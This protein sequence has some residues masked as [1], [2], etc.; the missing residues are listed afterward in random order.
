M[1]E[2]L[3][4][5]KRIMALPKGAGLDRPRGILSPRK[6]PEMQGGCWCVEIP[7][8]KRAFPDTEAALKS[9]VADVLHG[10]NALHAAGC[11]HRNVQASNILQVIFMSVLIILMG[12]I[13]MI[14]VNIDQPQCRIARRCY[15]CFSLP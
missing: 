11:V 12:C 13:A 2:E 6:M 14:L 10:L 1:L 15:N 5:Y 7:L 3:Q 9:L 8:A 4:V